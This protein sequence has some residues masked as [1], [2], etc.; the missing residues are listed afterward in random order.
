MEGERN[1]AHA[2]LRVEAAHR[3]HEPDI[4]FLDEV[5]LREPVAEILA[6]H[7]DDEPQVRQDELLRRVKVVVADE[8]APERELLLGGQQRKAVHGLDVLIQIAQGRGRRER[9][10]GTGHLISLG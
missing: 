6:A 3:L 8:A 7:G 2:A 10:G 4:A 5:G 1:E 9:Q